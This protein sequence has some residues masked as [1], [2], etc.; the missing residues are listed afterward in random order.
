[1]KWLGK[2]SSIVSLRATEPTYDKQSITLH[3]AVPDG[4]IIDAVFFYDA[5]DTTSEDDGYRIIV[6][7]TGARWVTDC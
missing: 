2:C 3:R 4:A 6:T 5:S 7:P 1:M